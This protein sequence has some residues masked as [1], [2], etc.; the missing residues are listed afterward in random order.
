ML[1][2]TSSR[3]IKSAVVSFWRNGW[4]ST[5]P[6]LVMVLTLFVIGGRFLSSVLMNTILD[7]LEERIDVSV[8]FLPNTQEELIVGLKADFEKIP[9]VSA[10]SYVSQAEALERFRERHK[11][12]P[13]ILESLAELEEN[14]LEASLNIS[15]ADTSKFQ[16]I[17]TAIEVQ[18]EPTIDK[19]NFFENQRAIERLSKIMVATRT[20]GAAI[21]AI[22]AFIAVLVAFNTVRLAIYTARDE[23]N[24]MRLV[25][26]TAWHIRGP[27]LIEGVIDGGLAAVITAAIYIPTVWFLA[28]NIQNFLDGINIFQ[29]LMGHLLEF[30]AILFASGVLLGILSS[31]LAVRRYL[32]V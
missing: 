15:A 12:N 7:S 29:Y 32:K 16:E 8:Y 25:G 17:V 3:I 9:N 1:K 27:F 23:I 6:V 20:T 30:F 19:I 13:L 21:A 4:L 18:E 11:N 22:L 2:E 10:V 24:V 26:A 5:A 31:I 28:P 14:P